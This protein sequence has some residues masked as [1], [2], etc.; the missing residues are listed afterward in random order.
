MSE[1][2][3]TKK[4]KLIGQTLFIL[5]FLTLN[6]I[7][8][9]LLSEQL[10]TPKIGVQTITFFDKSRERPIITEIMYPA[11]NEVKTYLPR[12]VW[13]REPE[14]R[15]APL[16]TGNTNKKKYPLILLSHGY[17]G[18]RLE[19]TWLSYALVKQGFIV[20]SVDHYGETW[21][22]SIPKIT[23]MPW[24]RPQ[25]ISFVIREILKSDFFKDKIDKE[26]I[27]FA[28]F[29]MGGLTGIWL[30]GGQA[31]L[32]KKPQVTNPMMVEPNFSDNQN[33]IDS[34]DFTLATQSYYDPIIK[35]VFLMSPA[36]G[37]AFDKAGLES[38]KTPT[39]IV[40]GENDEMVPNKENA[41]YFA[42]SI[43][44]ATLSLLPGKVGHYV[45]L[46]ESTELGKKN[47]PLHLIQDDP[48]INR[49]K[50]HQ[51]VAGEAIKFFNKNFQRN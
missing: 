40:S 4:L 8:S 7:S 20:A 19:S 17:R 10:V 51:Q 11:N 12:D 30:A 37:F 1:K 49:Y 18:S 21:S 45:F 50:I 38:I 43:P 6:I 25:D 22:R 29:S 35:A 2:D 42:Q 46:N 3:K 23:L 14:A 27:G 28:G 47:L 16:S 24:E 34:I 48:S 39:Y 44:K 13:K 26:K 33:L 9:P 36:F 5:I 31:N 15:N 41:E 32:Y